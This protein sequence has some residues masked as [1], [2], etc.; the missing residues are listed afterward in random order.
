MIEEAA[1]V[2]DP[3]TE[4][5]IGLEVLE[6]AD[7]G[8]E[9]RLPLAAERKGVLEHR[10][11]REQEVR[12]GREERNVLA[13]TNPRARRIDLAPPPEVAHHRVVAT[14]VDRA[15]VHEEV[16]GDLLRVVRAP[17]ASRYAIGS[18]LLFPLVIT[19]TAGQASSP[20]AGRKSRWWSGV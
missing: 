15:V 11:D 3:L 2:D 14:Q 5:E 1:E 17:P 12:A 19:S 13:G 4:C 7:V 16:V 8:P 18:S 9:D 20:G 6:I 10:P